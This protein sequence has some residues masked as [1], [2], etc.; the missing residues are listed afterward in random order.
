MKEEYT[1][2]ERLEARDKMERYQKGREEA[3]FYRFAL[4]HFKASICKDVLNIDPLAF[5]EPG[6]ADVNTAG[7]KL[8]DFGF[9][10]MAL[11]RH[12]EDAAAEAVKRGIPQA[13]AGIGINLQTLENMTP[14]EF[15]HEVQTVE[16]QLI[17]A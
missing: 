7:K 2:S 16:S 17:K 1:P 6:V 15:V 13:P 5:Q 12:M 3:K 8:K 9:D 4:N 10:A 14:V 11:S